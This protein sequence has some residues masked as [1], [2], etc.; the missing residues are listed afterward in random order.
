MKHRSR[1]H[2]NAARVLP[3]PVGACSSVCCPALMASQPR[4]CACVGSA[5]ASANQARVGPEKRASGSEAGARVTVPVSLRGNAARPCQER[6]M[7]PRCV[8]WNEVAYLRPKPDVRSIPMCAS[9]MAPAR[10][11]GVEAMTKPMP[12]RA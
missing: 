6:P 7:R 3:L 11:T 5:N 12:T 4:I 9:R 10:T 1:H 2:R 8:S